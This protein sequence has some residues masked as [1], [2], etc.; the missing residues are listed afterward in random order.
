MTPPIYT[1]ETNR[2]LELLEASPFVWLA[3][4]KAAIDIRLLL[5]EKSKRPDDPDCRATIDDAIQ[6]VV[7]TVSV[8]HAI[9]LATEHGWSEGDCL[10][11]DTRHILDVLFIDIAPL[12]V[13]QAGL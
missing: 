12:H 6:M 11:V 4:T 10:L 2:A 3:S 9:S 13:L 8:F 7:E 5:H 1:W